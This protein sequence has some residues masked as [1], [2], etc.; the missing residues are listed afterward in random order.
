MGNQPAKTGISQKPASR[1]GDA[2]AGGRLAVRFS[3]A[4][5]FAVCCKPTNKQHEPSRRP[6]KETYYLAANLASN[7]SES[8]DPAGASGQA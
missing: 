4:V 1:L 8:P 5:A 3:P 2:P 7:S 6:V